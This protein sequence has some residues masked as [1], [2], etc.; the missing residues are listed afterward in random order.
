MWKVFRMALSSALV[1]LFWPSFLPR[2]FFSEPNSIVLAPFLVGEIRCFFIDKKPLLF[3][4]D[5]DTD[6]VETCFFLDLSLDCV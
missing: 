6:A 4:P 3:L 2:F 5:P 1:V